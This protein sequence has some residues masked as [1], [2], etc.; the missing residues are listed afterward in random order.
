MKPALQ[1]VSHHPSRNFFRADWMYR[2]LPAGAAMLAAGKGLSPAF[3]KLLEA[4]QEQ[5]AISFTDLAMRFP[6]L[7]ADD[8]EL[9][10]AELCRMQM[11]APAEHALDFVGA[12]TA[13]PVAAPVATLQRVLLAHR[14]PAVR[15]A[16]RKLLAELPIELIEAGSLEEADSA[17]NELQPRAIVLGPCSGDFN[18]LNLLHVLKHPRAPR[19]IKAFLMLDG[20]AGG[21]SLAQAAACADETIALDEQGS[22]AQRLARQLGL[23]EQTAAT[24][25]A[26]QAQPAAAAVQA[27]VQATVQAARPQQ[28]ANAPA[29]W[30]Q[31]PLDALYNELLA[32]CAELEER[33]GHAPE[34]ALAA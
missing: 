23:A 4:V 5:G 1:P 6:R 3:L 8:L 27:T 19:P 16:W 30:K 18:T 13:A 14:Q 9:W 25:E 7:D 29:S 12:A 31:A 21:T 26:R 32:I 28:A 10:L 33:E 22:L 20:Q 34:L 2:C 15:L 11:I 24:N 17:Y